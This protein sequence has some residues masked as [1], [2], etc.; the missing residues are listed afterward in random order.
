MILILEGIKA[1]SLKKKQLQKTYDL[2]PTERK[3]MSCFIIEVV[4]LELATP[5]FLNFRFACYKHETTK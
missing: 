2:K 5:Q 4:T 3:S 1:E